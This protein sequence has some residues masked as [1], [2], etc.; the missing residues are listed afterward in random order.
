MVDLDE[1]TRYGIMLASSFQ[2]LGPASVV[3]AELEFDTRHI[4]E[5][6][7]A[8]ELDWR[9]END[10]WIDPQHGLVWRSTQHFHP[11]M[12]PVEIDLLKPA[13]V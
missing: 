3:I 9:F 4:R 11:E 7:R 5:T 1:P 2:D 12:P 8:R 6:C 13:E 10:Y